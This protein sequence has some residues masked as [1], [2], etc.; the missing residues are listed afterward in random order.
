MPIVEPWAPKLTQPFI[1]LRLIKLLPGTLGDQ[2]IKS[3]ASPHSGSVALKQ[4]NPTLKK[5][6]I[7]LKFFVKL[8]SCLGWCC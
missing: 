3:K 8:L 6:L 5:W 4:L 1:L 7:V 2:V